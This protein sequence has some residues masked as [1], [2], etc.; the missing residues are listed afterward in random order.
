[1]GT[2]IKEETRISRKLPVD[3]SE[4]V[5]S[6]ISYF[7]MLILMLIALLPCLNVI[8][9]AFSEG[10][11]VT[12]G[13]V[14]FWPVGLQMETV[15]K[16]LTQTDFLASLKNSL[17]VTVFG[18]VVSMVTSI[19]FAYP[20]SKPEL[21]GR[22]F[23]IV[24]CII[25]MVF[26]GGMVPKYIVMKSLGLLDTF[27][28]LILHHGLSIFN[29]LIIKNYFESLPESTIESAAIDGASDFKTLFRIVCPMA[30]PVIA[31]VSL[32]Y[33]VAYWNLYFSAALYIKSS[34]MKVLQV[35]LKDLISN[36]VSV[37]ESLITN[38]DGYSNVT[39][40]GVIAGATVLA[41]V[42]IVA[43]YPFIQ[44]FMIKGITIG[45]EKG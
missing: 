10:S 28:S 37:S 6:F 41:L 27:F 5:I 26:N 42:P 38:P 2:I 14:Y 4:K 19:L 34:S 23:F 9:K 44:R 40:D 7:L 21:K 30:L 39:A 8:S 29:M 43:L 22:R 45:S 33:A 18:V 36:S 12:S 32:L 24:I 13:R 1:M 3:T 15:S 20:L 16:V 31:T 35:F 25:S 11:A 17:F